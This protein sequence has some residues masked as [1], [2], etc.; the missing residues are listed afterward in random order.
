M[1]KSTSF[2]K[3]FLYFLP[4][5]IH[6]GKYKIFQLKIGYKLPQNC[7]FQG[8]MTTKYGKIVLHFNLYM[9]TMYFFSCAMS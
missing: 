6:L 1:K 8:T 2:T 9:I 4:L 3:R 7:Q 5:F